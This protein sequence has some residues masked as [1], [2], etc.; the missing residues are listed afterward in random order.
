[1]SNKHSSSAHPKMTR[2][3]KIAGLLFLAALAFIVFPEML[4]AGFYF[5]Q[6][7]RWVS[8]SDRLKGT[9]NAYVGE[10]NGGGDG[11]RYIDALYPHP[12]LA[13]V[14]HNNSP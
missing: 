13:F 10:F 8:V 7:G 4:F 1:M 9:E 6:D 2:W 5:M 12:Y 3:A 11:C 14:Y